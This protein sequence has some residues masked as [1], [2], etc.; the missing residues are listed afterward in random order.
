MFEHIVDPIK[1]FFKGAGTDEPQTENPT[2]STATTAQ[3]YQRPTRDQLRQ[4][5]PM[6]AP[7]VRDRILAG[8]AAWTQPGATHTYTNERGVRI[9]RAIKPREALR[10]MKTLHMLGS[11]TL[12]QQLQDHKD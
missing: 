6:P 10:A 4:D 3:P 11:L 9:T 5:W 1:N 8:L 2:P 12:D 7:D